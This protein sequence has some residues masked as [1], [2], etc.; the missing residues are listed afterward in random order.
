MCALTA[1]RR[2]RGVLVVDHRPVVGSKILASGGGRSNFT[3]LNA[4]INSDSSKYVSSNPHFVKSA[5]SRFGP[6]DFMEMLGVAGI[7]FHEEEDGKMFLN[8]SSSDIS[9]MLLTECRRARV[10][11]EV[12]TR[13][14]KIKKDGDFVLSGDKGEMTSESLVIATGGLSYPK[15]GAT[16]FGHGIA[17]EFGL[18][19]TELRPGLAPLLFNPSDRRNF[20]GLSG[21]SVDVGI[22]I[23]GKTIK[24]SM[25][26]THR[27]LS[28]PAIL[29][30]SLYFKQGDTLSIDLLP[31]TDIYGIF[32]SKRKSR[33]ELRN[34][35][36]GHLP[37][38]LAL[39]FCELYI[40]SKPMNQYTDREMKDIALSL[41]NWVIKPSGAEGYERAE[42]TVGGVDT[43]ELSSKT[44]ESK[45]VR[46]L[47]FIG[48][49]MDVTGDLG[50]YNL[51]WAWSSGHAAGQYA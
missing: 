41:K 27:G 35:L 5:L 47:Y 44:M 10:E 48:E 8:R 9:D 25:L 17:K 19:V 16:G 50:G 15:L 12:N 32:L 38:R 6:H 20:A 23:R 3:N 36:S 49:V 31:D 24:G 42:V 43:E 26:F 34:L 45:K 13:V 39:K 22:G 46:G 51:Q 40:E 2:G 4:G 21:V 29:N 14:L 30:A 1:G 7:G 28:G 33:V 37:R 18:M 11:F